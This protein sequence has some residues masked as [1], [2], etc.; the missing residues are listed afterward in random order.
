MSSLETFERLCRS[1]EE[2][3]LRLARAGEFRE[4]D[5]G[6]HVQRVSR[7]CALLASRIGIDAQRCEL[8]RLASMLHDV[9]K[10]GIED[11]ILLKR[12]ALTSDEFEQMK[13]HAELGHG[14]LSGSDSEV[15][16]LAATIA[17]GH[18]EKYDGSGYPRGLAGDAIPLE[19]R[20]ASIADAFDALSSDRVYR[21]AYPLQ[22]CLHIMRQNRGRQ[23]DP[24]LLDC[25]LHALPRIIKIRHQYSDNLPGEQIANT[26]PYHEQETDAAEAFA[27]S[28]VM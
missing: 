8:I 22:K 5:T 25:F 3:I 10:I 21:P 2:V 18:H 14:I 20:I 26:V 28:P 6:R 1:H 27:L 12:E 4:D 15:L 11:G 24:H 23:F 7:Y 19:A 16:Q 9:G 13:K 17:L